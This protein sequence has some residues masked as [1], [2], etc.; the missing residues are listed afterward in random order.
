MGNLT[1]NE[2]ILIEEIKIIQDIIKRMASNSFNL[3]AWTITLVVAT[4]LFN[5]SDK[6]VFIAYISLIAFWY[7][8]SY[9]L[10]QER[11]FRKV[12]NWI[13]DYRLRNDDKLF[14]LN[15]I[16][17]DNEVQS[18]LRIMLTVSTLPFYFGILIMLSF[19]VCI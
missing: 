11:L 3:K 15:P 10:R 12:H 4:I 5:G 14:Y 7:L 6:Y 2:Q 19:V 13:A 8:D 9:Y 18:V 16:Q 17:F 1:R